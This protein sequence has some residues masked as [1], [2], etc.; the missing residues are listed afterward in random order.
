MMITSLQRKL[1]RELWHIRG[2]VIA[3]ALVL[4]GGV[5]VCM[6][7]LST[8]H[9]L[10]ETRDHYYR[11][12]RFA[13]IFANLKRAPRPL[14]KRISSL[15]GVA[16][17]ETRVVAP[18]T[19]EVLGFDEP[20]QGLITSIPD[21]EE[22]AKRALNTLYIVRGRLPDS[23]RDN[24]V[25]V[26]DAFAEQHRLQPADQ[27]SV[28]I[29]G[30]R[31]SLNIVGIVLS[32]EHI[33]Q[34]AP[35]AMFPD[36]KRYAVM[37]MAYTPLAKAYDMDGAFNDVVVQLQPNGS[38]EQVIDLIDDLIAPYGGQGAYGRKDQFSNL[39]LQE[40]FKQLQT[41]A[42]LFPTIFLG[43]A[44]FL[45]NVVITRLVSTQREIVA[46]LKAFG[47]SNTAIFLHYSGMVLAIT[48]LGIIGG[49]ILGLWL[50]KGMT[51]LYVEY[52]RFPELT[53]NLKPQ[54]LVSVALSTILITLLATAR[55][56]MKAS[57]LPPAEA[58]RP[59]PPAK[60]NHTLLHQL[61]IERWLSPATKMIIRQLQRR[62]FK[63]LLSVI[64]LAMACAIMMVGNFQKDAVNFMIHVQFKL[65]QKQDI[66][67]VF[68]NPV[69]ESA[70]NSLR[71]LPGVWHV[72]GKRTVPVRLKFGHRSYR[73]SVQGLPEERY[74][75]SVLDTDLNALEMPREGILVNQQLADKLGFKRGDW[76]TV[77]SLEGHRESF[78]VQVTQ[79][80]KQFMGLGVYSSQAT[81]NRLM[82]EGPA[83]NSA[84]LAIDEDAENSLY[85]KLRDM[86]QVAGINLRQTV[87]DSSYETLDRIIL[88]FTFINALLGAVI[89]FGVVY[90]TIR[91]ALAERGR[92]LASLRVLGYSHGEVAY[93]LLGE[94]AILTL[95]SF[96]IGFL[97]GNS[98]CAF[99][100]ANLTS[101]LYRI[102][103]VLTPY[104]YAFS[105][106]IVI[107]SAIVS[108]LLVWRR[109]AELD[110][111]EVLKTRE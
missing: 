38:S 24:E 92:E 18:V 89:A 15:P 20:I 99:M 58:M 88:W 22:K 111:V 57:S 87:I 73:T 4:V 19:L 98:L 86:P 23:R 106:L 76:V 33:Y 41:M 70:L 82:R 97:I 35:G 100:A 69:A 2:Q 109:L 9:S 6:M 61:G 64:G 43:V 25:V 44:L 8:Y 68:N 51:A 46:M 102:P 62:P 31:R 16:R 65:V 34:I 83:V 63:T 48:L 40:E 91:I 42:F 47:Y 94:L 5:G 60:F 3:I 7:S 28:I 27:L 93:I 56:V 108:G 50:G 29:N 101:D 36:F 77:E 32:P 107:L 21:Q 90:N 85:K 84:L 53:Y 55:S 78:S 95:M 52:Y 81:I 13:D 1:W 79:L 17:S 37:W 11:N 49:I 54:I 80:S 71:A 39:F 10:L 30:R 74:L 104:T 14:N 59:E 12:Y 105:A 66:E 96:P 26:S 75:Q 103:L 110:L 67:V 72:E 45:L